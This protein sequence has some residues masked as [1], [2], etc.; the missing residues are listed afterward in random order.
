MGKKKW[1]EEKQFHKQI[2]REPET[3]EQSDELATLG[4]LI[5]RRQK[6]KAGPEKQDVKE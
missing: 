1:R 5:F 2:R 4:T 3:R 6:G